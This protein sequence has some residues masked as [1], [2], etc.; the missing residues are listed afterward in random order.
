MQCTSRIRPTRLALG[1]GP[2]WLP[3]GFGPPSPG[4]DSPPLPFPDLSSIRSAH[5]FLIPEEALTPASARAS[6]LGGGGHLW[7][8]TRRSGALQ[9]AAGPTKHCRTAG[10]LRRRNSYVRT[11]LLAYVLRNAP[12]PNVRTYVNK[13]ARRYQPSRLATFT[14]R[15]ETQQNKIRTY[16]A[17]ALRL[18]PGLSIAPIPCSSPNSF[19]MFLADPR[20]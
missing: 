7:A 4:L 9:F 14:H 16:S 11:Y 5:F 8:P 12:S 19:P 3:L 6:A 18:S 2:A 20:K 15:L 1:F 10:A 13:K 17:L